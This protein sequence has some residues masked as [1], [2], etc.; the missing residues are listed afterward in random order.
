MS[1][2]VCVIG[3]GPAGMATATTLCEQ[4]FTVTLLDE[5]PAVGGQIYR[6]I[7]RVSAATAHVLGADYKAGK[8][9]ADQ[10]NA[11]TERLR[12]LCSTVVWGVDPDGTVN[13][14]ANGQTYTEQF[15]ALVLATGALERPTPMPGW[16]LPGVMTAGAAQIHLKNTGKP[17]NNTV[18]VGNGPLM[19][20]VASQL[21]ELGA[22]PRALVDTS[23]F[24]DEIA[25]AHYL[26]P[27]PTTLGYLTKGLKLKALLRRHGVAHLRAATD[28]RIEQAG[29]QLRLHFQH[30]GK[31][32]QFDSEY[33]LLHFGVVPNIQLSKALGADH[34]WS[35]QNQCFE[36]TTSETGRLSELKHVWQVGDGA[37]ILG[38]EAAAISGEI[39]AL[40]IASTFKG[41]SPVIAERLQR[42]QA[43]KAKFQP[44]RR[45]LDHAYAPPKRVLCP[46]D[47]TIVCRCEE[48]TAGQIKT[49]IAEG[50]QGPNQAKAFTRCGMGS[51]QG[52]YC[53]LTVNQLFA[54]ALGQS[55]AEVGYYRIRT[56][57]KP[58]TLGELASHDSA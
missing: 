51:C 40:E 3:A 30:N 26:R 23:S 47:D 2:R 24:G 4:G 57:I 21:A 38:A 12:H 58:I 27:T 49:A 29:E 8:V 20:L 41:S 55:P 33:V 31:A 54:Q 46:S 11:Q 5:Q 22:P 32:Q 42:L 17:L 39:A 16:T 43:A 18:L 14:K 34:H 13:W 10:L 45:F 48:I 15:D 56:P 37:G 7:T 50:A 36:P 6:N 44:I 52:R 9:L 35:A 28:L 1:Q 53:G 25:A 19:Y